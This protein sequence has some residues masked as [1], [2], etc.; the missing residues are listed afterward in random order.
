VKDDISLLNEIQLF[1]LDIYRINVSEMD[2]SKIT[3]SLNNASTNLNIQFIF[4]SESQLLHQIIANRY[5]DPIVLNFYFCQKEPQTFYMLYH[6]NY[7]NI[8]E[9]NL[10]TSSLFDL[11]LR[12]PYQEIE[13]T[14]IK[15][16]IKKTASLNLKADQIDIL[17]KIIQE[18]KEIDSEAYS[19]EQLIQR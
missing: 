8:H 2:F 10:N 1:S 14:T 16:F 3:E 6:S 13:L 15:E 18:L 9:A 11:S 5:I 17:Q 4:Y 19:F 7:Q 12:D